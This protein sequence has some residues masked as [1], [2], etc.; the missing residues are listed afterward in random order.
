MIQTSHIFLTQTLMSPSAHCK[1]P[2]SQA[3]Y[4][5]NKLVF[6][7]QP[8]WLHYHNDYLDHI[9]IPTTDTTAWSQLSQLTESV[10][11]H[12][13]RSP[14]TSTCGKWPRAHLLRQLL[15]VII[16]FY[17]LHL[18]YCYCNPFLIVFFIIQLFNSAVKMML[19]G[20]LFL[21]QHFSCLCIYLHALLSD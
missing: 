3:H 2:R 6:I 5:Q 19:M 12:N 4:S 16:D 10:E 20:F 17:I 7:Q 9:I 18:P 11:N 13:S 1:T 21:G 14:L 8:L 15:F